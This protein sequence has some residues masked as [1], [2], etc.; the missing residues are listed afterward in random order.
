MFNN[1]VKDVAGQTF[2]LGYFV[3]QR[4]GNNYFSEK[5]METGS[6]HSE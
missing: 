4:H 3:L 1:F 5:C 2:G 6:N